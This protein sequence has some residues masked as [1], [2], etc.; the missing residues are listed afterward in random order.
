MPACSLPSAH[1]QQHVR[2]DHWQVRQFRELRHAGMGCALVPVAGRIHLLSRCH[3]AM[4]S[5][6]TQEADRLAELNPLGQT[7]RDKALRT[8]S[9]GESRTSER[10]FDS[11][12]LA[13]GYCRASDG[14]AGMP[15]KGTADRG[16][17]FVSRGPAR[18]WGN[19]SRAFFSLISARSVSCQR[20]TRKQ[21]SRGSRTILERRSRV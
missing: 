16:R 13:H 10:V 20:S 17:G 6:V 21:S 18:L 9:R 1:A 19:A 11:D 3:L 12:G 5:R 14:V 15:A 7:T 8:I 4:V 2:R